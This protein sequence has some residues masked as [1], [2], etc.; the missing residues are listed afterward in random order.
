MKIKKIAIVGAGTA[1]WLAANHLGHELR[2]DPEVQ[3]TVIESADVPTIGVGE[4]TVPYVMK[5][6]ERFGISEAEL[7]LQCDT[8]FKQGIKFVDWLDK[9]T[10]GDN[11][12]YHPFDSPYPA[13]FDISP[14]WLTQQDKLPFDDIGIQ[15]RIAELGLAPK[16]RSSAEYQG[17]LAYAYH[18]NALKFAALLAKNAKQRFR[19]VH[20]IATVTGAETDEQGLIRCL[21]TSNGDQLHFDFYVDCS[22]FASILIDKT[23]K[24]PFISKADELLTDRALVQ[25]IPL[26]DGQSLPPYTTATAHAA[27]W[28]WD[29]PL[30]SRRGTGFVYSSKHMSDDEARREFASYLGLDPATF[31]PRQ[32]P[33]P[34]GYREQ[35]WLGNCVALGLAQGFV[36]PLEATSILVTDFA[37]ELL[38]RHFPR[39]LADV[40]V[41]QPYYNQVLRYVWDG[42]VDF[43][44]LHYFLSDRQDSAFWQDNRDESKLSAQL[45]NRL[46]MFKLRP[47]QQ[48]DFFSRFDLFNEKNFLYVLY[49]MKFQT[50]LQPLTP[51]EI[52]RSEELLQSNQQLVAGASREFMPHRAWLDAL[53]QAAQQRAG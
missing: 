33:M 32:I 49:G 39:H 31:A 1:G 41:C 21:N 50:Q 10:H 48:S 26:T 11:H 42:V 36:E 51:Y 44:K 12:Y 52:R 17:P 45:K 28:I 27:G 8:T 23:L 30:T 4:G 16:Q 5:G 29:I 20:Q 34:I 13:G 9:E 15:A 2:A 6:L 35:F 22:G 3:I 24:V 46:A 43:I 53:K 47:P 37:A 25:Q 40:T 14:Y 19:V 18:F 7:L 38:A